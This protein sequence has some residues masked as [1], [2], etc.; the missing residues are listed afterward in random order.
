[1][2]LIDPIEL[3]AR[4]DK[5][6]L[7]NGGLLVYAPPFPKYLRS[8]GFWDECHFGDLAVER[9][10][11]VS[12]VGE[13][14]T[15]QGGTGGP[16]VV[17]AEQRS[18]RFGSSADV[19]SADEDGGRDAR[20]T[21][22][23][24]T[25]ASPLLQAGALT[26]LDLEPHLSHWRW[27]PDRVTARHYLVLRDGV[28]Y[29]QQRGVRIFVDETRRVGPDGTLHCDLA[30]DVLGGCEITALHVVAWT[31]RQNTKE[32]M[33]SRFSDLKG[34]GSSLSYRQQVNRRAHARGKKPVEL[35]V[36]MSGT[37]TADSIEVTPSHGANLVP[38]LRYTP[39][40]DSLKRGKLSGKVDGDNVLGSL[41][42]AGLHWRIPVENRR[43]EGVGIRVKVENAAKHDAPKETVP[44]GG[45]HQSLATP[46]PAESWREF[47][48][49]VPYFECSDPMLTRYYWY[50]WYGLRLNAVPPGGNYAA[51]AVTEG[52]AYFRGVITYS[53]MCHLNECKWL[54]DPALARGCLENHLKHQARAGHLPGHIYLSYVNRK[55][56]YHTDI[57]QCVADLLRHYPDAKWAKK[58]YRPLAKLLSYYRKDRDREGLNLYDIRDQYETGQEFTSRYFHADERADLYGWE[59]RL[60]L[61][62]VD[63]TTYV[64]H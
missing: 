58:I 28:G 12:F 3:L 24:A 6:Y 43:A 19:P 1:M 18:A 59:H 14:S 35:A 36:T 31:V 55:G 45:Y 64:Y 41:I 13:I 2:P 26:L 15:A 9:L 42:Y 20:P 34:Y 37:R 40:W 5:W 44:A 33:A 51:P 27:Y 32:A 54:S 52:I 49:L 61:K 22:T 16:P 8:P 4:E 30:F 39:L 11:C 53:L 50:R 63:V 10:L 7:G 25:H 47:T 38:E 60:R 56:F 57:G 23:E 17:G 48:S 21:G 62:G 46:D 29:K